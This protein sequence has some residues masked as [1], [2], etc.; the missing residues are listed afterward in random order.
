M[1]KRPGE[2]GVGGDALSQTGSLGDQ[3]A[4]PKIVFERILMAHSGRRGARTLACRVATR[5][6]IGQ[7]SRS[8]PA[9]AGTSVP[10]SVSTARGGFGLQCYRA[11]LRKGRS[12]DLPHCERLCPGGGKCRNSRCRHSWRHVGILRNQP[13]WEKAKELRS[14]PTVR[15]TVATSRRNQSLDAHFAN[16]KRSRMMAPRVS[17]RFLTMARCSAAF[18]R[19]PNIPNAR[20]SR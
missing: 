8:R 6:D 4:H 12:G 10:A 14:S 5:G 3:G 19:F 17:L 9:Q 13:A 18:S 16:S 15:P 20:P 7:V 11:Q 2:P 1:R